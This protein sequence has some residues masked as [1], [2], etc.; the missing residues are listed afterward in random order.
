MY[1][2]FNPLANVDNNTCV[3]FIYGCTDPSM[4]NY[5]PEANTEDFSCIAYIYGCTDS[6]AFNYDSLANTD[7]GSCVVVVEGCMDANAYNYNPT[8]NVN[9][10]ASCLYSAG[11]IT[12]A[13]SPY[14]L[15]DP[16][17][18]WVISVDDYCC[19]NQW[20]TICQL[21]YNHCEDGWPGGMELMKRGG[22][23]KLYPNPT[24]D[25]IYINKIVELSVYN[26]VGKLII[27]D[28]SNVI[29]LSIYSSGIYNIITIF[30]GNNNSHRIIKN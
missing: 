26:S 12:G 27:K 9:D 4:L 22:D 16:C 21:T 7:N 5:N 14:W 1:G 18:A 28:K 3:P 17:Y 23:I 30:E 11:C 15:N 8:A 13:G 6:T 20:D 24:K 25:I 19:E 10:S 2:Q 29:D